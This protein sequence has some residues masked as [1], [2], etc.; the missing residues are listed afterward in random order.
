MDALAPKPC[1]IR[2]NVQRQNGQNEMPKEA[3]CIRSKV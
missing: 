1:Q 3:K 2:V